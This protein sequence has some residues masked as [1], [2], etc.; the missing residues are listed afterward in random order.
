MKLISLVSAMIFSVSVMASHNW[1]HSSNANFISNTG[2][3]EV[4]T[5]GLGHTSATR[6][7]K[8][9]DYS[10]DLFGGYNYGE[11]A[12]VKNLNNWNAGFKIGKFINPK[13]E[14]Y[15]QE[16]FQGNEYENY[17]FR[18]INELGVIHN[19]FGGAATSVAAG[20]DAAAASRVKDADDASAGF[21]AA[22]TGLSYGG[23]F[24]YVK[25]AYQAVYEDY[26]ILPTDPDYDKFRHNAVLGLGY[27]TLLSRNL[28]FVAKA[29]WIKTLGGDGRSIIEGAVGIQSQLSKLF[30]LKA[31]YVLS[32]NDKLNTVIDPV[33]MQALKNFSSAYIISLSANY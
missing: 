24:L 5:L 1:S 9:H 13:T 21:D 8:H 4:M 26:V 12:G 16:K 22:K 27:G 25:G 7:G 28:A 14:I 11:D 33:T 6:L 20:S 32:Y 18:W 15:L 19:F 30:G 31:E 29:D 10:F 23:H 2:N 3:S 17:D